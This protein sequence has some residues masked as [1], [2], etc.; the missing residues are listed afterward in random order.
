MGLV[1]V[2]TVS[3]SALVAVDDR[4]RTQTTARLVVI[5]VLM[6]LVD[7]NVFASVTSSNDAVDC[8]VKTKRRSMRQQ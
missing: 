3:S 6:V 1:P 5:L 4:A 7:K 8:A 2:T